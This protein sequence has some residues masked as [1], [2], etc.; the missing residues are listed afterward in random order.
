MK[1]MTLTEIALWE[2]LI[3]DAV[4]AV[5]NLKLSMIQGPAWQGEREDGSLEE[6]PGIEVCAYEFRLAT[7]CM[8]ALTQFPSLIGPQQGYGPLARIE[9]WKA[10]LVLQEQSLEQERERCADEA[11]SS[12]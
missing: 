2:R 6:A 4:D 10:T 8:V 9:H 11:S 1:A 7:S 3:E 12:S 5:Q